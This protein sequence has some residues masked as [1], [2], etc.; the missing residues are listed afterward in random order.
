MPAL[1]AIEHLVGMQSQVPLAPYYGLW[2]RLSD[3]RAE[4]LASLMTER[5]A[6]R[7]ALMRGTVHLVSA[8]DCRPLRKLVQP[9]FDRDL[10]VN[11]EHSKALA[12]LDLAALRRAAA[13]LLSDEPLSTVEIGKQL[14]QTWPERQP[15]SLCH[16]ARGLLCLVQATPRGV[17]GKGGATRLVTADAWL[18]PT[19]S[20][21]ALMLEGLALRYFFSF[22]PAS[23]QD[24]Q[25]WCGLTR[26]GEV[27][28]RLGRRLRRFKSEAGVELYDVANAPRPAA[29][30]EAPVRLLASYDNLLLSHAD[31]SRV[32]DEETRRRFFFAKNGVLPGAL[33]IDGFL[34]GSWNVAGGR[35]TAILGVRPF[36]RLSRGVEAAIQEEGARLLERAFPQVPG[37]LRIERGV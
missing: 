34:A 1:A 30:T 35:K 13:K 7:V 8:R 15:G 20:G 25:A 37:D 12:G 36:I 9:V 19:A 17:W 29:D 28:E 2:S 14:R 23:V 24:L 21:P 4:D 6:V 31:R 26:L 10:R 22:G 27:V 11:A 18:G 3:F 5:R 33:L 32:M 16:G